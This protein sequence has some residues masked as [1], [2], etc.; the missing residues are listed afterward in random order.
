METPPKVI[1]FLRI[2]NRGR[3]AGW[4]PV[5][6]LL[7]SA[8]YRPNIPSIFSSKD[9]S[10]RPLNPPWEEFLTNPLDIWRGM[11][12]LW[13]PEIQQ[14]SIEVQVLFVL[15]LM[16]HF[17]H[18]PTPGWIRLW[19]WQFCLQFR[20]NNK[21]QRIHPRL[22]SGTFWMSAYTSKPL[23]TAN[24]KSTVSPVCIMYAHICTCLIILCYFMH[25]MQSVVSSVSSLVAYFRC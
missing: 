19:S 13:L 3:D 12:M 8:A 1:L 9:N 22:S 4:A 16:L 7:T 14:W 18:P 5:D 25:L 23:N 11:L 15:R 2:H 21:Q 24:E 10:S 6:F 20:M 17:Q